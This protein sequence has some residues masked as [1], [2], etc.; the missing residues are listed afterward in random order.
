M[1]LAIVAAAVGIAGTAYGVHQGQMAAKKQNSAQ[2]D[3]RD[4]ALKQEKL[5]EQD[6]NRL[7]RKSPNLKSILESNAS[8]RGMTSGTML[9]GPQG[10]STSD[11]SLGRSSLL[12][13]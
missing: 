6:M 1:S 7:N 8:G 4:A 5:A 13:G 12:G 2:N 10:V 9:T 11:L 3:A